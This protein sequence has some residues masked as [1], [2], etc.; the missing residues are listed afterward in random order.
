MKSVHDR[1]QSILDA[2]KLVR[3]PHGLLSLAALIGI[4][5]AEGA[6]LETCG[7]AG[8]WVYLPGDRVESQAMTGVGAPAGKVL[9]DAHRNPWRRFWPRGRH[10]RLAVAD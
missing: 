4:A 3:H 7:S 10:G 2:M 5:A 1:K 9:P 6:M 8:K